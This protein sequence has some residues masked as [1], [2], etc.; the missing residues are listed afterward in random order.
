MSE[1]CFYLIEHRVGGIE[2]L[3]FLRGL[4]FLRELTPDENGGLNEK[5]TQPKAGNES[6]PRRSR[7]LNITTKPPNKF[8]G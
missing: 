6:N 7:G 1:P 4:N 3:G 5:E 8:G 2:G